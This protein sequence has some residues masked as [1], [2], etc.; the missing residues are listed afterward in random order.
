MS[1]RLPP[2]R[3][4]RASLYQTAR[5]ARATGRPANP[6]GDCTACCTVIA[7]EEIDKP[8][9]TPCPHL[10]GGKAGSGPGD[11]AQGG[12]GGGCG[13]YP[14]RPVSCR[15]WH[16]QWALDGTDPAMRPDRLGVMFSYAEGSHGS[17]AIAV[18]EVRPGAFLEPLAAR[19]LLRLH[20]SGYT[21]VYATPRG[22]RSLRPD[23]SSAPVVEL[24]QRG[25]ARPL[26]QI[27]PP[28]RRPEP[29]PEPEDSR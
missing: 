9:F 8:T 6:C 25:P 14:T 18:W 20:R 1:R 11:E 22:Y 17:K 28:P 23:G 13:I 16:C 10:A 21:L 24:N 27:G 7:V 12:C 2:S 4:D 29:N 15:T 5:Q 3:R 26:H 19:V